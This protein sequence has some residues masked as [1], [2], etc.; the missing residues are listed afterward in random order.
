MGGP[1]GAARASDAGRVDPMRGWLEGFVRD[2]AFL[3]RY[4]YYAAVLAR[5]WPVADP[6]IDA[7]A[8]SLHER[9]FYLHVNPEYFL[10]H[11]VFLRGI[12]LHEV[13]HVVLGHLT[14]AKL[15]DAAHPDL[16]EIAEECSANEHV[17]EPLPDPITW[18]A[19]EAFGLRAG[20]STL[21][22][23]ERLAAAR[24]AGRAP[25]KVSLDPRRP[26]V[27]APGGGEAGRFLDEHGWAPGG[28]AS[29]LAPG[30]SEHARALAAAAIEEAGER[31]PR[32]EGRARLLA[33]REPGR[34]IEELGGAVGPAEH[35][36]DWRTALRMFVARIRAPRHTWA[37]PSRRFP[38][39]VGELPG[40]AWV[41]RAVERPRLLVAVDTSMSMGERELL[42][43][44]RQLVALSEHATIVIAECD[45]I[46]Q[47]I[48]PFEGALPRVSGRGGTD[49]RPAFEPALL[50]AQGASGVIYFTDGQGPWPTSAPTVPT[51]WVLT[52]PTH[53]PCPFGDRVRLGG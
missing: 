5:L 26:T 4:P 31:E 11:P 16:M 6:S 39:R 8:V 14:N 17:E 46:V 52:K 47:R 12:L 51:L 15:F 9:R 20:Q 40:R 42:E 35:P 25:P 13:H 43:I 22:R 37:R 49:L 36:M 48:Y 24:D 29:R 7:L 1:S 30:A 33:G 28:S 53:F 38:S 21:E 41:S 10:K 50:R 44:A 32:P 19:F 3:E 34:V 2:P 45:S 18:R 23:Y 27:R